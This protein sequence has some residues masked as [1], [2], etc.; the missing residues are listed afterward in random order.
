MMGRGSPFLACGVPAPP[1]LDSL[2]GAHHA[3]HGSQDGAALRV[4]GQPGDG[5]EGHPAC[6]AGQGGVCKGAAGPAG[7]RGS[8]GNIKGAGCGGEGRGDGWPL[9]A[10]ATSTRN[11]RSRCFTLH[12]T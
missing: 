5:M 6:N 8:R 4:G 3:R 2:A 7:H 9:T 11:G 12:P 1:V 10:A